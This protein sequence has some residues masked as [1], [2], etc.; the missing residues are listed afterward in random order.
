MFVIDRE[1]MKA[2]AFAFA[3]AVLTFFGFM[4]GEKIGIGQTPLVAVSYL[5]VAVVLVYA[6]KV[7]VVSPA[8]AH[9][10]EESHDGGNF[11]RLKSVAFSVV[12]PLGRLRSEGRVGLEE[13]PT[14][15]GCRYGRCH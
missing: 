6:A 10:E 8:H 15:L 3:A 11:S 2:A 12:P 13:R 1:F 5:A 4:H 14:V 7:A 9:E